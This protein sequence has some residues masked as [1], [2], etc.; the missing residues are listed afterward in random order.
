MSNLPRIYPV[1]SQGSLFGVFSGLITRTANNNYMKASCTHTF[2]NPNC[3]DALVYNGIYPQLVSTQYI[4]ICIVGP[5]LCIL[6]MLCFH[7]L[8]RRC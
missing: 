7:S 5:V 6:Q 4:H 2:V 8:R 1:C 3:Q